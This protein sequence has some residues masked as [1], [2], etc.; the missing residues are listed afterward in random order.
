MESLNTEIARK[1]GIAEFCREWND[2]Q[3][4][5]RDAFRMIDEATG[6]LQSLFGSDYRTLSV[7]KHNGYLNFKD[8]EESLKE[9]RRQ[10][11]VAI[12]GQLEL[13]PLL[14]LAK[15]KE[16]DA[17]LSSGEGLPPIEYGAVMAT[18]E[19]IL[20]QRQ[21]FL[22]DKVREVYRWLRPSY[23]YRSEY[24]TNIKSAK[25][26]VGEK[27][28]LTYAVRPGYS[29]AGGFEICYGNS[30]DNLRALDQ[31]FH[32]LDGQ[33]QNGSHW[34]DLSD[35]IRTQTNS[36]NNSFESKYFAGRCFNNGNLH[37]TFRRSDLVDR[38][39]LI[40]GGLNLTEGDQ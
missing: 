12:A 18:L 35:A 6:K 8:P 32:L 2:C 29:K 37:L 36:E 10:V 38:F 16:L 23:G 7:Q 24:K 31:V 9:L 34:G 20:S 4:S 40:C 28:I 33:P 19:S 17:Q 13:R 5:I 1:V 14:S 15:L 25:L 30:Q 39:N 11:W 26:G 21:S 22:E 3:Q 27:I